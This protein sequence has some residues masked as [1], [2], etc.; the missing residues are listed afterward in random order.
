MDNTIK[1]IGDDTFFKKEE[2]HVPLSIYVP[3]ISLHVPMNRIA[4]MN[5]YAGIRPIRGRP[6][7]IIQRPNMLAPAGNKIDL[8]ALY[9]KIYGNI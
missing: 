3:E 7:N 1:M 2:M 9:L 4:Y 8:S 6:L 5:E